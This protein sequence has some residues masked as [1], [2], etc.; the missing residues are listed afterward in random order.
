[1]RCSV[2]VDLFSS[3]HNGCSRAHC[4]YHG[5][6]RFYIVLISIY[7]QFNCIFR[8]HTHIFRFMIFKKNC[9][10]C[11]YRFPTY[12]FVWE[13]V[14]RYFLLP[15]KNWKRIREGVKT[16]AY[17]RTMC[18]EL[19]IRHIHDSHSIMHIFSSSLPTHFNHSQLRD[20]KFVFPSVLI[21]RWGNDVPSS[22]NL[23]TKN[24]HS[25]EMKSRRAIVCEMMRDVHEQK[26]W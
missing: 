13:T 23:L 18:G 1:M 12:F 21:F 8:N 16:G 17:E 19:C 22:K 4:N 24:C 6:T 9:N 20:I 15:M 25:N 3:S 14:S 2:I 5:R 26:K 10:R 7:D 11:A